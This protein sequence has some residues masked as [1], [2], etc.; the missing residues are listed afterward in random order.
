MQAATGTQPAELRTPAPPA[1]LGYLLLL[2]TELSAARCAG[3][4]EPM[5]LSWGEMQAWSALT[6][7]PLSSWE[8]RVLRLLDA[9][10]LAAWRQG[11]PKDR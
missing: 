2:F 4:S 6:R 11:Q 9:T 8:A 7:T 5:P 10:W 1:G 3:L